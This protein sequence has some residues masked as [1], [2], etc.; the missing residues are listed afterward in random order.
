MDVAVTRECGDLYCATEDLLGM[1]WERCAPNDFA[2]LPRDWPTYLERLPHGSALRQVHSKTRN[3]AYDPSHYPAVSTS[4]SL[5]DGVSPVRL[6]A[7]PNSEQ[8]A[9]KAHLCPK[10][11][12][13]GKMDTWLCAASAALGMECEMENDRVAPS[14]ALQGS[15]AVD[16]RSL[17][18]QTGLNRSPFNF[19]LFMELKRHFDEAPGVIFLPVLDLNSATIWNG[20]SY[21]VVIL[22]SRFMRTISP[23]QMAVRIGLTSTD[24]TFVEVAS[25]SDI[26]K[27]VRTLRSIVKASAY[28]LEI[29]PAP[30]THR[31]R[32]LWNK[33][34]DSVHELRISA[35]SISPT[36]NLAGQ[37]PVPSDPRSIPNGKFVAKINL[38]NMVSDHGDAAYPDPLFLAYK[39][40]IN[41][42]RQHKFQLLAEAEPSDLECPGE[43]GDSTVTGMSE[44]SI[45]EEVL[46]G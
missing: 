7:F 42:T 16:A 18:S 6:C 11:G 34:H 25:S 44:R 3:M 19:L 13:S 38:A 32:L 33:Y 26:E 46:I 43:T 30:D 5:V 21:S 20:E 29:L 36:L 1:Q 39:S 23:S 24:P 2:R 35:Q 10:T 41:W 14:K 31:A 15:R 45:P 27:A 28:C 4:L 37:I 17:T 8:H 22:C 12:I 9:D 40:S